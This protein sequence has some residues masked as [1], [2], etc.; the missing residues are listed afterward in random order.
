VIPP[1][2]EPPPRILA[3]CT[4]N[5]SRSPAVERLLR[6]RLDDSIQ[7]D[8]AGVGAV[9]GAPIDPPVADFLQAFDADVS[10]FAARQ[11]DDS[12]V[13]A[14]D[15][16]LTLTRAHRAQ[17]LEWVP[18]AV[19]RTFTLLEFTRVLESLD[20]SGLPADTDA[21]AR[22]RAILPVVIA[23]RALAPRPALAAGDDVPDPYG[24]DAA[25]YAR[26]LAMIEAAT[27]TMARLIGGAERSGPHGPLPG[28]G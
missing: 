18:A 3:V 23:G 7:I 5:I 19:R 17:V 1:A 27:A 22:L 26:S 13:A 10:G 11:I 4:G 6:A 2:P 28:D 15:L 14:A 9:V 20:L 12:M 21:G 16:V 24:R 8:S 25:A